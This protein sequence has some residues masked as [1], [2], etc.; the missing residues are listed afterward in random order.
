MP[1]HR[2]LKNSGFEPE[3]IA[4]MVSAYERAA[5]E[6]TLANGE[7]RASNERIATTVIEIA[8]TG[9]YDA[10]VLAEKTILRLHR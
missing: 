2:L 4:A 5:R 3:H 7:H 6:L 8:K 1:I 9:E 10:L